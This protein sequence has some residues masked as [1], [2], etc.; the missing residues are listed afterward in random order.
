MGGSLVSEQC[1]AVRAA[2]FDEVAG[3]EAGDAV[4]V[5][6]FGLYQYG[7][8]VHLGLCQAYLGGGTPRLC[9]VGLVYLVAQAGLVVAVGDGFNFVFSLLQHGV[10]VESGGRIVL[11]VALLPS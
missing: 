5:Q 4:L 9:L 1:F 2:E 3:V 10:P 8:F 11:A 7:F 6:Q